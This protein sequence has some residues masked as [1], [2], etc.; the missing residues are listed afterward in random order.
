[1]WKMPQYV[2]IDPLVNQCCRFILSTP[3]T[4]DI[5]PDVLMDI[6]YMHDCVLFF[7]KGKNTCK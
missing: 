2:H 5:V 7:F 1:M 6:G 4:D 3:P